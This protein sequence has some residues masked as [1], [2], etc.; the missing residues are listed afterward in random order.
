MEVLVVGDELAE[1]EGLEEPGGVGEVPLD[2]AGLGAGLDH[3]VFGR[4]R[5]R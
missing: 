1:D 2:G 4:E 3:E 5:V